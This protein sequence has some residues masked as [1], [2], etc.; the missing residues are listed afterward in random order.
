MEELARETGNPELA[1]QLAD[2]RAS[3]IAKEFCRRNPD[4][5]KC[6]ANWRSIVETM[7]H[8]CLGED[9]MD[10]DEAQDILINQGY[11]TVAHLEAAYKALDQVGA[12]EYP[13]NHPRPLKA[14]QRL[15]AEQLAANGDVL[16]G[17]VEYVKGRISENA[18]YEVAFTLADP[19]AFTADPELRPILEE[20]CYFCWEAYRKDFSPS[21]ERRRFMRDYCAGRFVTVSFL[22][23]AWEEC[24][25]AEQ[26]AMRSS[27][28]SQVDEMPHVPE[29]APVSFDRLADGDIDELYHRTLR[30]YARQAK[31][32]A[33]LLT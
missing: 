7:A 30:E 28:F 17:I 26:D 1:A 27:L 13:A 18:G 32:Q 25:R 14:S 2:E 31:R 11:W 20:A 12:L 33:D 16:G 15:R 4:Y 3:D 19:L 22:D 8:N 23:A 6:D 21:P 29:P 5:L 24:K 10:A 9:N